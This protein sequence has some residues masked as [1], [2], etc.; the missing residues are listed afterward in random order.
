M[1]VGYGNVVLIIVDECVIVIFVM[2]IGG[3]VFFVII[4]GVNMFMDED[5]FGNCFVVFMNYVC[6][7]LFEYKMLNG[8]KLC[9]WLYY[10]VFVK[11]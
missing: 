9:V 2:I 1:M 11:F 4:F 7:F 6:E 5:L 3:F 8:L 10:K